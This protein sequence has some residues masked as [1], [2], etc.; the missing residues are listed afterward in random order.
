MNLHHCIDVRE[1]DE[2][3]EGFNKLLNTGSL[4]VTQT[5]LKYCTKM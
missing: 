2:M 4:G 3:K 1:K 5:G